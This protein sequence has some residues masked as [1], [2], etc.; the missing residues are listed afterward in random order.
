MVSST[1]RPDLMKRYLM[2]V[3]AWPLPGLTYSVSVMTQGSLLTRIFIPFLTSF[4]PIAGHGYSCWRRR[5]GRLESGGFGSSGGTGAVLDSE[6]AHDNRRPPPCSPPA[7]AR[8]AA[9]RRRLAGSRGA[10][11]CAIPRE[12]LALLGLDVAGRPAVRR[13]RASSRCGCRAA[14]SP[15]C[16]TATRTTRCCARCCRWTTR[17]RVVPGFDLDAVGDGAARAAAGS[18]TSTSGRALL[19]ATGSCAIHC[20]YCFRRHFPYA[21]ETAA[22]GRLARGRGP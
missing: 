5:A 18:S 7:R 20:R 16:A 13:S 14:S 3:K 21:E 15:A 22:A 12:L 11:P 10:R 17:M 19:V 4:M 9:A 1:T 2:R 8:T 6:A